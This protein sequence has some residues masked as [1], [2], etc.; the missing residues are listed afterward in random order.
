MAQNL[1]SSGV[2]MGNWNEDA[3]LEEERMKDFLE[4]REQGKLL[5]QRNRRLKMHLLRPMQLSISEDGYIHYGDQV[6]L[7][8]PD[9]SEGEEASAFLG[10]DLN[11]CMTPDEIQAYLSDKLELPC[12]LSAA[13]TLV[14][15]GRNTFVVLS[16]G[17]DA[18]GQVLRY[19]QDFCLGITAG[20][21]NKML[22]LSS[23]H[24]TL[25]RSAKKSWL[26]EVHL[27]DEVSHLARWQAT[28][29]NPQ[30]RLEHE[31]FPVRAN[32]KL[33]LYHCHT[34]RGLAVHRQL[35]LRTYFGKEAEVA[36]HTH[37]DSHRAE[38]PKNYWMLVTGNP[39]NAS[40]TMP[41]L[42]RQPVED[43][44]TVEPDVTCQA[45]V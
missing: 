6:M 13:H 16:I 4:K 18:T 31:G 26:Q 5:I 43:T 14:P 37:L 2:R 25:L 23:D 29:L 35:F 27:T 17:G 21:D 19:G 42:Q 12:G 39:R 1:Y 30:L 41:A 10:G 20:F 38:K 24:K 22:Y 45:H 11:L 7:V 36:A 44:G 33:L 28:F 9:H 34:N 8:N 15:V 3:Y 32:E 40:S